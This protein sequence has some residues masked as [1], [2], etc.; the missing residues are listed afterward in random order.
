MPEYSAEFLLA[1]LVVTS[2]ASG[3]LLSLWAAEYS[4]GTMYGFARLPK[5]AFE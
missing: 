2:L 4:A 5:D 1:A 3:G